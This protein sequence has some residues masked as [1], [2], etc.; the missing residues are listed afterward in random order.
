MCM[1]EYI[2]VYPSTDW[3]RDKLYKNLISSISSS[4]L[5]G[6]IINNRG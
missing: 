5:I 1:G 2:K 4:S 3:M 6:Q